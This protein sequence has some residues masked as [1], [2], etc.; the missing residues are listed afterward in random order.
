MIEEKLAVILLKDVSDEFANG[1]QSALDYME[2][3]TNR[4]LKELVGDA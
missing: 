2:E 4:L 1:Y 3:Q